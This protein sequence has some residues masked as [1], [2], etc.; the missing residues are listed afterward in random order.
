MYFQF[1]FFR[2]LH[3]FGFLS[4]FFKNLSS[5]KE[6]QE[7]N[8]GIVVSLAADEVAIPTIFVRQWLVHGSHKPMT[9]PNSKNNH[10]QPAV[11]RFSRLFEEV[12]SRSR[13]HEFDGRVE[14]AL[15][16]LAPPEYF[17]ISWL[18]LF[19]F[20]FSFNFNFSSQKVE[21]KQLHYGA[22]LTSSQSLIWFQNVFF[23]V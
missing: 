13:K 22:T 12:S 5:F 9:K 2:L 8:C 6:L 10:L 15:N 11:L 19:L 1:T 20:A 16:F 17:F 3:F 18:P 4:F 7:I 23:V 21:S 14:V